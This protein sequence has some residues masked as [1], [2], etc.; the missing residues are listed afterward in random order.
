MLVSF[1]SPVL[2]DP[3]CIRQIPCFLLQYIS[4]VLH[5]VVNLHGWVPVE[6]LHSI[7]N[8]GVCE[9]RGRGGEM[10]GSFRWQTDY[11]GVRAKIFWH[12]IHCTNLRPDPKY[13]YGSRYRRV[14]GR[15]ALHIMQEYNLVTYI[16]ICLLT[17][18]CTYE[19]GSSNFFAMSWIKFVSTTIA[20]FPR[21]TSTKKTNW[22]KCFHC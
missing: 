17:Q 11:A 9:M 20:S 16:S 14:M 6:I 10:A 22:E 21:I 8:D 19:M 13:Q 12:K 1:G 3:W 5:Y 15:Q 18:P 2:F 4:S 7:T